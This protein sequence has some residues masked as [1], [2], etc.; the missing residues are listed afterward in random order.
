MYNPTPGLPSCGTVSSEKEESI[1]SLINR[2]FLPSSSAQR[3]SGR[4]SLRTINNGLRSPRTEDRG[5]EFSPSLPSSCKAGYYG[6]N[7]K[8]RRE[9]LCLSVSSILNHAGPD[10]KLFRDP[11]KTSV[12][13]Q[14]LVHGAPIV[15]LRCTERHSRSLPRALFNRVTR[16]NWF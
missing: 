8:G 2:P 4:P 7:V 10:G 5:K 6:C 16:N 13:D 15:K 1:G 11:L 9:P 3:P 14:R 12:G